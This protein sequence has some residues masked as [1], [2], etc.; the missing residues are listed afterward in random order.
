MVIICPPTIENMCS[1]ERVAS[2]DLKTS[3]VSSGHARG[4]TCSQVVENTSFHK[5]FCCIISL[6][7]LCFRR[8][9]ILC[10]CHL[11]YDVSVYALVEKQHSVSVLWITVLC[12]VWE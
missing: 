8:K 5:E 10:I 11:N 12:R 4:L 7:R 3:D 2:S 9:A 6:I 1:V